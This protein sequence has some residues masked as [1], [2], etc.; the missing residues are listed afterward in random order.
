MRFLIGYIDPGTGSMLVQSV[1]GGVVGLIY[2]GRRHIARL[3]SL[4]RRRPAADDSSNT[5]EQPD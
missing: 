4:V 5:P 3:A 2:V 1:V